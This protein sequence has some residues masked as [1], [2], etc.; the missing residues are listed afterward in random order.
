MKTLSSIILLLFMSL[1]DCHAQEG[2]IDFSVLRLKGLEF[3]SEKKAIVKAFGEPLK[4]VEPKYECGFHSEDEQGE[5]YY[6]LVYDNIVFIGNEKEKYGIESIDF[7]STSDFSLEYGKWKLNHKTSINDFVKIFGESI[8]ENF[9][10]SDSETTGVLLF[11][12]DADS[13]LKFTFKSGYL[14]TM[15][16]W[17]PC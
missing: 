17:S 6:Q 9:M 10:E 4:M 13:G 2:S 8:R 7:N 5:K 16:Y 12:R 11:F 14:T 3:T 15:E 1:V